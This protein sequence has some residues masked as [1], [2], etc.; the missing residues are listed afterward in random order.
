MWLGP[1]WAGGRPQARGCVCWEAPHTH[2]HTKGLPLLSP[3]YVV[4]CNQVPSLP[5]ISFH[6]G[7]RAYTLTSA[8]YVLQVRPRLPLSQAASQRQ[9]GREGGWA[10]ALRKGQVIVTVDLLGQ[11]FSNLA[12]RVTRELLTV[13]VASHTPT[14]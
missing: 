11:Q 7:G 5:D 6:L 14:Y 1:P 9:A 13:P 4:S 3:Q 12:I 8:D 10:G 2:T